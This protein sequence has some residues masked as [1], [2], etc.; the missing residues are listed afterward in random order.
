VKKKLEDAEEHEAL[1]HAREESIGSQVA[2][3]GL[4]GTELAARE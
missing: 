3:L 4:H 2:N 1:V